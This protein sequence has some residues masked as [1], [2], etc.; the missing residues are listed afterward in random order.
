M[1]LWYLVL[2]EFVDKYIKSYD[3][4][5]LVTFSSVEHWVFE[6]HGVEKRV[7]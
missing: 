5:W 7:F 1:L 3:G 4:Y 2:I 6:Q